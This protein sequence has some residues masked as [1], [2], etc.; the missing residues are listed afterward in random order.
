MELYWAMGVYIYIL[1]VKM[2]FLPI[3]LNLNST[4]NMYVNI[5][6]NIGLVKE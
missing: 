5:S 4:F 1:I 6:K 2:L 3:Y